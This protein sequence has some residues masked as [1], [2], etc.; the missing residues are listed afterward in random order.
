MKLEDIL[1]SSKG[2]I[3]RILE[4]QFSWIQE[5]KERR[6]SFALALETTEAIFQALQ[7]TA[8]LIRREEHLD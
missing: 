2:E 7:K 1:V 8:E 4:K 3:R 6:D 5:G